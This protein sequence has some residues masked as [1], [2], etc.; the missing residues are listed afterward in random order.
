MNLF[1]CLNKPIL[2]LAEYVTHSVLF[3]TVSLKMSEFLYYFAAFN[4][5]GKNSSRNQLKL[6]FKPLM[7]ET[8]Q[9]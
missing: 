2:I 9:P 4:N 3:E 1:Y 8:Y 5:F 6:W 7:A